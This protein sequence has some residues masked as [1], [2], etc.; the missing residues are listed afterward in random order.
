MRL[1]HIKISGFKSFID[2]VTIY[3]PG[4]MSAIVGPNGAGKS[5][6]IDAVRWVA[7][8]SS[9]K[10][11]RGGT[12]EDVIFNG[13]SLKKPAG[14]ASVELCFDNASGKAVGMWAKYAEITVRRVLTRDGL[15]E[16]FIN[17]NHVRRKDVTE[18]FSGSGFGSRSYSIIEQ[19]MISRIVESKPEEL[20]SFVEEASGITKFRDKRRETLSRIRSTV[21]NLERLEDMRAEVEG[22]VRHLKYQSDQAKRFRSMKER[23]RTLAIQLLAFEWKHLSE[24]IQ[25]EKSLKQE[26]ELEKEKRVAAV[27][28]A[29][30]DLEKARKG[31]LEVQ[32][33]TNKIQLEQYQVNADISDAERKIDEIR[34]SRQS[35]EQRINE[36][37]EEISNLKVQVETRESQSKVAVAYIQELEKKK[38]S[39]D[40]SLDECKAKQV[41][42]EGQ[43]RQYAD[44]LQQVDQAMLEA[45]QQRE[46]VRASLGS[47]REQ[48]AEIANAIARCESEIEKNH[49]GEIVEQISALKQE[50]EKK[51]QECQQFEQQQKQLDR[52][53]AQYRIARDQLLEELE[54]LRET[55]NEKRVR[56]LAL[57]SN[58]SSNSVNHEKLSEWIAENGLSNAPRLSSKIEVKDGLERALDRVLGEKLAALCVEDMD[59]VA[60]NSV[61]TLSGRIYLVDTKATV[62]SHASERETLAQHVKCEEDGIKNLLSG[63]YIAYSLESALK[64][65][66]TLGS[67]ECFVLPDGTIVGQNWFSPAA[68]ESET[69]GIMES[70]KLMKQYQHQVDENDRQQHKAKEQ[71][72]RIKESIETAEQELIELN[73]VFGKELEY[74]ENAQQ[75]F[76][77]L[78]AEFSSGQSSV[79]QNSLQLANLKVDAEKRK[80][81]QEE[82][83][84][85][86]HSAEKNCEEL[87]GKRSEISVKYEQTNHQVD[88]MR[89]AIERITFGL[90]QIELDWQKYEAEQNACVDAIAELNRRIEIESNMLRELKDRVSRSPEIEVPFQ[91][92]LKELVVKR[93]SIDERL[94]D[95]FR[96]VDEVETRYSELDRCRLRSQ[97]D[98]EEMNSKLNEVQT[99]VELLVAKGEAIQKSIQDQGANLEEAV[100]NLPNDYDCEESERKIQRLQNKI[101]KAGAVNLTAI[102]EYDQE[103]LRKEYMDRQH[104][105]LAEALKTLE[106]TIQKIDNESRKRFFETFQQV[107]EN[108]QSF[109]PALFNGGSGH[110]ELEGEYPENAG[111]QIFAR[112]KGKRV[113]QIQALSGG[114]KALVA[115]ALLLS[116]FK[117]KP[118]PICLLDE[119]DAP[120]DDENVIRLCDSLRK[121]S[122]STQLMMITHNKITMESVDTLIGVT[123][124]EPNVSKVLSVNIEQAR[125]YAA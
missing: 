5:N 83:V 86:V 81:R 20:S 115:V 12:L 67:S 4:Y 13:S 51:Q 90:H 114:E 98:V 62:N 53:L 52:S 26:L 50:V 58:G 32:E 45:V 29:E 42:R 16:Y 82:L 17:S 37:R 116:L 33:K 21:A 46:S 30:A 100:E 99:S 64:E 84:A 80:A 57:E 91:E 109:L 92:N 54:Q 113:N 60:L 2:P 47:V 35:D 107:N 118:S 56:L 96:T 36:L 122:E 55:S 105:D 41:D 103:V 102:E 48:Q 111:I 108:F 8:E 15:S 27:R 1:I 87:E 10:N 104:Q 3:I 95:A 112:P 18:L 71:L 63:V 38:G 66:T 93:Q 97:I 22:R 106:E 61:G 6:V 124:P 76:R 23:E 25:G 89:R 119:I 59:Q 65:R 70:E 101:E 94:S 68:G 44:E 79:A 88:E 117:L 43:L 77:K 85:Q 121:L 75:E 14:R 40:A 69:A 7:G 19:G 31:Q 34:T 24:Q 39:E 49:S 73:A 125:Q 11:L 9:A 110:L 72:G 120:L 74:L 78:E 123:M 28:S